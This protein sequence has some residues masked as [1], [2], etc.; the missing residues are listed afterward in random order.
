MDRE[1]SR[2]HLFKAWRI[3]F[4]AGA[5][6]VFIMLILGGITRLTHSGL[7]MVHWK[8]ING[9]LP[10]LT[11]S[12]WVDAFNSYKQFPEYKDLNVGMT[13]SQFKHIFFW[14]YLHRLIARLL[15]LVFL[16]PL[17]WF[18]W[19]RFYTTSLLKKALILFLLGGGQGLMGWYM[20][21]SGLVDQP[22]VSHLRLAAHLMFALTIMSCCVW[23]ALETRLSS[24]QLRTLSGKESGIKKWTLITGILLLIQIAYGAFVAGL[25]AG[26]MYNTFPTMSGHWIA[27]FFWQLHPAWIN[28]INNPIVV[29]WMHRLI[30]TTLLISILA[31]TFMVVR[32]RLC[33]KIGKRTILL[34]VMI[35]LQYMLGVATLLLMVP[36]SLGVIHQSVG[37][38][39][40]MSWI[41]LY[42]SF[43]EIT[44][45]SQ[46]VPR[47]QPLAV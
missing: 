13:L 12:Q 7:S 38:L 5:V 2:E 19:K 47:Q 21:K 42:H 27:P 18:I 30:G 6:G 3:W 15:G 40:F 43:R 23:F 35:S 29:Q 20:V 10:P 37:I 25:K 32:S 16:I 45:Q 39:T 11:K 9:V 1:I 24:K 17:A 34:L 31:M 33:G 44:R 41:L 46:S 28:F 22:H 26:K 36:V 14:E 8:P 4:L